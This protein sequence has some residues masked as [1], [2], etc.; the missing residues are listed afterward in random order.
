MKSYHYFNEKFITFLFFFIFFVLGSLIF[1][2]YGI[3]IDEDNS[4]LNGFVSLKYILEIFFPD[5][6]S[7]IDKILSVPK[8]DSYDEQGNGVI[9]GVPMAFFEL[10]FKIDDSRQYYLIRHFFNY[11]IFFISVYYFFVII[12]T[13][14]KSLISAI[15]GA[16][17][18]IISPRIFAESFYN[19]K[20]VLFLSVYIFGLK[21]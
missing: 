4:R 2:D 20:D 7:G 9:F 10:I 8:I 3:S 14:Y 17:F 16:A 12:K 13:R 6:S 19:S 18:L 5:Y 15:L 1:N 11:L 21:N